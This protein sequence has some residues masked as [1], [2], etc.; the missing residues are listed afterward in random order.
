[1][2]KEFNH[3]SFK[4][5]VSNVS[6]FLAGK[7]INVPY[8]TLLDALSLFLGSK[9]WNT[10]KDQLNKIKENTHHISLNN[11]KDIEQFLD[12]T[13]SDTPKIL[14]DIN[15]KERK[16]ANRDSESLFF[17]E[18]VKMFLKF[19]FNNENDE[20]FYESLSLNKCAYSSFNDLKNGMLLAATEAVF[21]NGS[22][23]DDFKLINKDD[24]FM[25]KQQFECNDSLEDEK[26]FSIHIAQKGNTQFNSNYLDI[27]FFLY[28]INNKWFDDYVM[29]YVSYSYVYNKKINKEV[30]KISLPIDSFTV[31]EFKKAWDGMKFFLQLFYKNIK[32]DLNLEEY[33]D[34]KSAAI[35]TQAAL[36]QMSHST[37]GIGSLSREAAYDSNNKLR[38]QIGKL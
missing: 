13:L 24:L 10:L 2:Q 15:I 14:E 22:Y 21:K 11:S 5:A 27:L 20:Y 36:N 19:I 29:G 37:T 26:T 30:L 28:A 12:K 4:K 6:G 31:N 16:S 32:L 38:V 34:R 1:M 9:N 3:N 8:N 17:D 25:S 33:D 18:R 35:F 7:D 23:L